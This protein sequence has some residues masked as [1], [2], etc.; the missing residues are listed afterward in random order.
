MSPVLSI[1]LTEGE[2]SIAFSMF[3][4]LFQWLNY[5]RHNLPAPTVHELIAN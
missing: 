1:D 2:Q 3:S 4:E 5:C